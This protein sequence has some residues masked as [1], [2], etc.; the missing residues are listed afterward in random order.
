MAAVSG[1]PFAP[2][3]AP[4]TD[5]YL[6]GV[7]QIWLAE[8]D[9][10]GDPD[11]NGWLHAGNAPS[12]TGTLSPEFFEHF[13]SMFGTSE[14]DVKVITKTKLDFEFQFEEIIQKH[15]ESFFLAEPASITNATIAGFA[16]RT[17]GSAIKLGRS[18]ELIDGSD[19]RAYGIAKADLTV[20]LPS[21]TVTAAGGRTLTFATAGDTITASS[22]NFLTDGFRAG[23]TLVVADTSSNDGSYTIE[24]VT[25]TVITVA[26]NLSDEGPISST[27]SITQTAITLDEGDDYTVNEHG[28][29]VFFLTDGAQVTAGTFHDAADPVSVTLAANALADSTVHLPAFS[30]TE[31]YLALKIYWLNTR[32][33][34]HCL[35]YVPKAQFSGSGGMQFINRDDLL[36]VPIT[37]TALKKDDNTAIAYVIPL[38][39]GGVT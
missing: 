30:R 38:P 1:A 13:S 20:K 8:L 18:Y 23:R 34:R 25:E 4:S 21:A 22:G 35:I 10:N 16:E 33:N 32:T 2:N 5:N 19:Q 27:A 9:D 26:E 37:A 6:K 28:G 24:E 39:A 15:A 7:A 36:N 29:E 31:I 14:P 3:A 11:G 17:L 12:I